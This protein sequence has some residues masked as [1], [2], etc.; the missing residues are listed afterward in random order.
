MGVHGWM[1]LPSNF[2][3]NGNSETQAASNFVE[4]S[5]KVWEFTRFLYPATRPMID[6][7]SIGQNPDIWFHLTTKEPGKYSL[8]ECPEGKQWCWRMNSILSEELSY[9]TLFLTV[10][11]HGVTRPIEKWSLSPCLSASMFW[12]RKKKRK[13]LRVGV[14]SSSSS[15]KQTQWGRESK[16][17]KPMN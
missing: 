15:K 2:L 3:S 8:A 9:G 16:Q 4:A 1:D 17:R 14:R 10:G 13:K 12:W 7:C 11:S 6:P 5:S